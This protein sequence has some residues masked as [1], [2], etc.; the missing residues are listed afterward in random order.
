MGASAWW[1][2]SLNVDPKLELSGPS[3]HLEENW[4][5][6]SQMLCADPNCRII[7]FEV[8]CCARQHWTSLC[9][10]VL[11][12]RR[13]TSEVHI[14]LYGFRADDVFDPSKTRVSSGSSKKIFSGSSQTP[15]WPRTP[16]RWGTIS[17]EL[18]AKICLL[19]E[20][21]PPHHTNCFTSCQ[22]LS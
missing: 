9:E 18:N 19:K 4:K 8:D 5:V 2:F 21:S 14:T 20:A 22:L 12:N 10:L 1:P 6:R 3:F 16:Q 17:S 13:S 11:T 7:V 15:T